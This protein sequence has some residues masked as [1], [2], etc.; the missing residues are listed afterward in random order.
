MMCNSTSTGFLFNLFDLSNFKYTFN[1][2]IVRLLVTVKHLLKFFS[3]LLKRAFLFR[4]WFS[5]TFL[6]ILVATGILVAL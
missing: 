2:H 1:S 4:L 5:I 3:V 6:K